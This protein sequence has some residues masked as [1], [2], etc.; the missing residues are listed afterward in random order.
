MPLGHPPTQHLGLPL[1]P[2]AVTSC[3]VLL[4]ILFGRLLPGGRSGTGDEGEAPAIEGSPLESWTGKLSRG[5]VATRVLAFALL[6]IS[7][8][9]G[10]AGS[11]N[12][13]RNIAPALVIGAAWPLLLLGSALVGPVWRWTDPWDGT[14]RLLGSD[15]G[16]ATPSS[17]TDDRSVWPAIVPALGWACYLGGIARPLQPRS[18]GA[19]LAV[20]SIL[21]VAGCLAFGRSEWLS[22]VEVFGLVFSWTARLRRNRLVSWRP[23]AGADVVL[24]VLA[25]GL[26]FRALRNTSFW[27]DFNVSPLATLYAFA[28][29]VVCAAAGGAL[30]WGLARVSTGAGAPGVVAAAAVP[31]VASIAFAVAMARYRLST[32]LQLVVILASDPFGFGW[33]LFGTADWAIVAEPVGHLAWAVARVV[34]LTAGHAVGAVMLA[35]RADRERR[36]AGLAGLAIIFGAGLLAVTGSS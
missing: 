16:G 33:N 23:P 8:A 12:E 31:A 18:V 36:R 11:T 34:V 13:L 29:V 2:L 3:L 7:I 22:R 35:R 9:A 19:A 6:A 15:R 10:R 28:G 24:G 1:S 5:Q 25:G 27:G 32:S 20:Y 14:A 21:T 4:L 26:V 17:N 30:L